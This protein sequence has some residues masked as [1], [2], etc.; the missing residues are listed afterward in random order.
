MAL[1]ARFKLDGQSP[2]AAPDPV[3]HPMPAIDASPE[4]SLPRPDRPPALAHIR[5]R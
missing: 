1:V 4:E 3:A 2:D 5:I